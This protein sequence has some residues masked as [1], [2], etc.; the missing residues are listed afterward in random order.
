MYQTLSTN[1]GDRDNSSGF[2]HLPSAPSSQLLINPF[3]NIVNIKEHD[4]PFIYFL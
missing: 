2:K 4:V 3:R 1:V